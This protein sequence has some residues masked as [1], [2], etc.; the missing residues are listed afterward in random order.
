MSSGLFYLNSLD[1]SISF[2]VSFFFIITMLSKFFIAISFD[3]DQT[4]HSAA[5]D[6]RLHLCQCPFYGTV[7][8]NG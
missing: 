3:P 2:M 1:R 5:S 8:T 7:G 4:L 6:L